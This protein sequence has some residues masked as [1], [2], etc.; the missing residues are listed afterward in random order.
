M[1]QVER[2]RPEGRARATAR[3]RWHRRGK[4]WVVGAWCAAWVHELCWRAAVVGRGSLRQT[5]VR[6]VCRAGGAEQTLAA[7]D[8]ADETD[9]Q[10]VAIATLD[11]AIQRFGAR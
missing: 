11:P 8:A 9:V 3:R 7:K 2:S 4:H 1:W 5:T 6:L 10:G